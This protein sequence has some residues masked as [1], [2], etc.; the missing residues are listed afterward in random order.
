M[1]K[2]KKKHKGIDA[3]KIFSLV[4]ANLRIKFEHSLFTINLDV[5][6]GKKDV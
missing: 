4:K 3:K 2:G 1:M 6:D 5:K